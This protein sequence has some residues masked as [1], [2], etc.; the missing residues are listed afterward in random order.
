VPIETSASRTMVLIDTH[1]LILI[2]GI[3]LLVRRDKET[4]KGLPNHLASCSSWGWGTVV[5][6]VRS[7]N[8]ESAAYF[9]L[10]VSCWAGS[11]NENCSARLRYG[12]SC[13][14]FRLKCRHSI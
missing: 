11:L 8:W 9:E 14:A 2:F 10:N 1:V 5:K 7:S 3:T 4:V 6:F 13:L 12:C